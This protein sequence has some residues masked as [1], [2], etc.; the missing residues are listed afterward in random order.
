[1]KTL[2]KKLDMNRFDLLESVFGAI[3][4]VSLIPY[5]IDWML[6]IYFL[7]ATIGFGYASYICSKKSK[8][9]E[10]P[11]RVAKAVFIGAVVYYV[12]LFAFM[13]VAFIAWK[14]LHG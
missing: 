10:T 8:G 11:K 12:L 5:A 7:P 4:A 6:A 13:T 9:E 3:A 1:M 14:H 2:I